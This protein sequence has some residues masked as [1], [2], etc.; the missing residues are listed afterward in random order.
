MQAQLLLATNDLHYKPYLKHVHE[1][2][3]SP[4]ASLESLQFSYLNYG[5]HPV[6]KNEQ[7]RV[8]L[9]GHKW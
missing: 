9:L 5:V 6:L 7:D 3:L 2:L 4:R 1:R 8:F